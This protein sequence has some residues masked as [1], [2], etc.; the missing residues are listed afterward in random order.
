MRNANRT[1]LQV[2]KKVEKQLPMLTTLDL[3]YVSPELLKV[4]NLELAVPGALFTRFKNI[5]PRS[6][7]NYIRNL[8]Q[9][10]THGQDRKFR[11]HSSGYQFEAAATALEREGQRWP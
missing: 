6:H 1:L 4:R 10:K 2:F 9:R 11:S 7:Y 3:Q 5:S 8:S